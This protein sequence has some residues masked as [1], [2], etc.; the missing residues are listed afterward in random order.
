MRTL[1]IFLITLGATALAPAHFIWAEIPTQGPRTLSV[2][3]GEGPGDDVLPVMPRL[4]PKIKFLSGKTS[5]L[6]S[7]PSEAIFS[8]PM[9]GRASMIFIPY[10][11]VDRNGEVYGLEYF[12]KA[13]SRPRE[14][15]QPL[16]KGFE[17][18]GQVVNNNWVLTT[19]LDGK[20]ALDAELIYV[21]AGHEIKSQPGQPLTIELNGQPAVIPVRAVRTADRGGSAEGKTFKSTRQWTSVLLPLTAAVSEGSDPVAYRALEHAGDGRESLR[22]GSAPFTAKFKAT[23]GMD[24][25]NGTIAW[26]GTKVDIKIDAPESSYTEHLRSQLGSL[27][28]HRLSRRFWEGDGRSAITWGKDTNELGREV[29][30]ADTF[31]SSY[32]IKDGQIRQ[33]IRNFKDERLRLDI[34]KLRETEPG[35]YLSAEFLSF[36]E[37]KETG[38][39]TRE[40]KYV[41]EF[42]KVGDEWLPKKRTV[43]GLD[44]GSKFF[45]Q[46][47]F[48]G[49][50]LTKS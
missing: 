9:Q 44:K 42:L 5:P 19:Y 47:T 35:R 46:V 22:N 10:G 25:L 26:D 3:L 33:V 28:M 2:Y 30:V 27:F 37:N 1:G 49:Y 40:L 50:Q 23:N 32:R 8:A 21:K 38:E 14:L 29:L 39:V 31:G 34:T 36:T 11:V 13:A 16:G 20:P 15:A 48:E 18:V 24:S 43:T 41:D 45:M 12:A 6:P 4:T 7:T 17:I